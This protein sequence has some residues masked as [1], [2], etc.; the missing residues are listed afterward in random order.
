MSDSVKD[1][2]PVSRSLWNFCSI[3]NFATSKR[4]PSEPSGST[5]RTCLTGSTSRRPTR[6]SFR[7]CGTLRCR[8]S[9]SRVWLPRRT[10]RGP[11]W[12]IASGRKRGFLA[13]HFL[14]LFL[15]VIHPSSHSYPSTYSSVC[16]WINAPLNSSGISIMLILSHQH[17]L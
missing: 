11:S 5:S 4:R 7:A 10:A 14:Q 16:H 17:K 1:F 12:S 13:R 15:Q 3:L 9:T 6:V 8:A 2:F